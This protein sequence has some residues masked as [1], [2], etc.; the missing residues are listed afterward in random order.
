MK[1]LQTALFFLLF[2]ISTTQAQKISG[3]GPAIVKTHT[4]QSFDKLI[5]SGVFNVTLKQGQINK[6]TI[7][8]QANIHEY[9]IIEDSKGELDI[10]FKNKF[11]LKRHKKINIDITFTDLQEIE[12][13]MVGNLQSDGNLKLESLKFEHSS[14]GKTNIDVNVK[15]LTMDLSTDGNIHISGWAGKATIESCIVGNLDASELHVDFLNI[16]NS[17]IGSVRVHA[18]IELAID[19][20]GIGSLHYYGD[21]KITGL[22]SSGIG[23]VK[24]H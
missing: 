2:S 17:S 19:H 8:A 12:T 16:D 7:E 1:L 11:N 4:V 24:Q 21:A 13:N 6:V 22:S 15:Q 5:L 9:I 10:H 23:T 14:V 18:D 3:K 20:S